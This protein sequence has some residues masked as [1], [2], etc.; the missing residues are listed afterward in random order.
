M[1]LE[2]TLTIIKPDGLEEGHLGDIIRVLE[3]N[4]FKIRAA[5]MLH[6]SK[7]QAAG[8]YAVHGGNPFLR[9]Y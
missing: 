7:D 1:N 6:L 5:K 8:F 4:Q 9:A 2:R 3:A